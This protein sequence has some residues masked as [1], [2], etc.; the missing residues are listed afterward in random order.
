MGRPGMVLGSANP[1][2][3]EFAE[4]KAPR[5]G[6]QRRRSE[7]FL[8]PAFSARYV[9]S[10]WANAGYDRNMSESPCGSAPADPS[11]RSTQGLRPRHSA[12]GPLIVT[13]GLAAIAL[14]SDS[15]DAPVRPVTNLRRQLRHLN[16]VSRRSRTRR[17]PF[18]MH[19]LRHPMRLTWQA[20]GKTKIPSRKCSFRLTVD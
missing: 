3:R 10:G 7:F 13:I 18:A 11:S 9:T 16:T 12:R 6:G 8:A 2:S 1:L 15:S 14:I 4:L 20:Q 17:R 5:D 19:F